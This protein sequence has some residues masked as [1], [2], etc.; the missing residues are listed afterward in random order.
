MIWVHQLNLAS[1][2]DHRYG[3]IGNLVLGLLIGVVVVRPPRHHM[4]LTVGEKLDSFDSFVPVFG[5]PSPALVVLLES[6]TDEGFTDV[7]DALVAKIMR[8]L[9]P[10]VI[11]LL[12]TLTPN[13]LQPFRV[14]CAPTQI[15]SCSLH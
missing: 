5:V 6:S 1:S 2:I 4:I 3:G 7:R 14:P 15:R 8:E 12:Q 13:E 11:S 9:Q 10:M